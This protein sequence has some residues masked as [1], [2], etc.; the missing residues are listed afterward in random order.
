ML[1]SGHHFLRIW[2]Y[3][4]P[5]RLILGAPWHPAGAQMVPKIIQ[6]G[7]KSML[8]PSKIE[9]AFLD[10]FWDGQKVPAYTVSQTILGAIFDQNPN[11]SEK[12]HRDLAQGSLTLWDGPDG[13]DGRERTSDYFS[14]VLVSR[15]VRTGT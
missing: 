5:K 14:S 10:R 3:L 6:M 9:V 11:K 1:H 2:C 4:V 7:P 12:R 8:N 13:L 15:K